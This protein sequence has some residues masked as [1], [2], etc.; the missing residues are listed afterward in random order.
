M[1]T[2]LSKGDEP[3]LHIGKRVGR[4]TIQLEIEGS[5]P[6]KWSCQCDCGVRKTVRHDHLVMGKS[7]GCGCARAKVHSRLIG[8]ALQP[9][10][11]ALRAPTFDGGPT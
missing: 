5:R 6:R 1:S 7:Q 3:F 8:Q 4:W 11:R 10:R 9:T 2:T